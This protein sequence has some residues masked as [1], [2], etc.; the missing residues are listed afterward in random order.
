M[1]GRLHEIR[2]ENAERRRA[3]LEL[4]NDQL[5]KDASEATLE[6]L[7]AIGYVQ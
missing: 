4:G 1:R 6:Q 2:V 3:N 5:L 7:R